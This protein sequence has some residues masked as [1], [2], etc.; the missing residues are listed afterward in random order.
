[1]YRKLNLLSFY[2]LLSCCY[3]RW[4]FCV[5]NFLEHFILV[6]WRPCGFAPQIA[7]DALLMYEKYPS[8]MDAVAICHVVKHRRKEGATR[9]H[10]TWHMA[11]ILGVCLL[12]TYRRNG[13]YLLHTII[14]VAAID[15]TACL[16]LYYTSILRSSTSEYILFYPLGRLNPS[17]ATFHTRCTAYTTHTIHLCVVYLYKM[18]APHK[19]YSRIGISSKIA[20]WC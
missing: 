10:Y 7:F 3:C 9:Y 4:F 1:M 20:F 12:H 15:I 17:G 18:N 16:L 11:H 13:I 14:V 8:D 19:W 2:P 5:P 6:V